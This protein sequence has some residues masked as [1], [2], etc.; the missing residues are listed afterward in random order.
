MWGIIKGGLVAGLL[1]NLID[2][3]NSIFYAAPKLEAQLRAW[4]VVSSRLMPPYFIL[5]HFVLGIALVWLASLLKNQG[6]ASIAAAVT[7]WVFVVGL[8]RLFGFGNVLIGN[9]PAS[10]FVA[11]S[12]SFLVG[13]LLGVLAGVRWLDA[14]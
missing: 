13:S 7:S 5:L 12:W 14:A 3:P 9:M 11:F 2:V 8:N 10:I 6:M 4:S 1:I